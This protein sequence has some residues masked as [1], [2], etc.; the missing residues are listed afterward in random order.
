MATRYLYVLSGHADDG[1]LRPA[2]D[3]PAFEYHRFVEATGAD[4]VS[5]STLGRA[6][7]G[8]PTRLTSAL[9]VQRARLAALVAARADRYDAIVT[10]GEDIGILIALAMRVARRR[11][12]LVV[13]TH[14]PQFGSAKFRSVLALVKSMPNLVFAPLSESLATL[15]STRHG[16]DPRRCPA[17]G[18]GVDTDF[19]RSESR[20]TEAL[21]ASAGTSNRD[22]ETLVRALAGTGLETRIAAHSTWVGAAAAIGAPIP[23]HVTVRACEGYA[24]LRALYRRA[25]VVVVPTHDVPFAAG[26]AVIAEAM[27][28]GTP[29]IATR[30]RVPSDFIESGV[31]GLL[32]PPGDVGALRAAI[33]SLVESPDRAAEMGRAAATL[34]RDRFSLDDYVRRLRE[35]AAI[36]NAA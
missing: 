36:G 2:A 15:L 7:R 1:V 20:P 16:I 26:F 18:Y 5:L 23:D 24:D 31:T 19:Y 25:R 9:L 29:V 14:G 11:T 30:G 21:V 3:G 10:S 4:V 35:A 6:G 34:M 33:L 17:V 27:A 22:Y 12:S 32:V 13:V 8:L 28:T